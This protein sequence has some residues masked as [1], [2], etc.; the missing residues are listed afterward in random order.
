MKKITKTTEPSS[1][2]SYR[3]SIAHERLLDANVY[4]DYPHKTKQGCS[5]GDRNNLRLQL[6]KEQGYICCYCMSRINC[7][8]SK[9]EHLKPQ[10][11]FRDKQIDY[12][13]LFIACDGGEGLAQNK[14]YCD[15]K[16]SEIELKAIDF[17]DNIQDY[18][19]YKKEAQKVIILSNNTDLSDDIN[20]L[21]LNVDRLA[22]NRKEAYD[23]V[24][25][26]LSI[27]NFSKNAIKKTLEYYKQMHNGKYEPYCE[28]IV[29][30][31]TKK[32][33][34]QGVTP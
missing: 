18:L 21:N 4:E 31:L 30:F 17:L 24:I 27:K 8:N 34:Q 14:Q 2:T 10:S 29:Y 33:R 23:K 3:S 6:L 1:L 20:T 22:K 12:S 16:K 28:M 25:S 13:N 15:T 11:Q 9:I 19:K 5:E 7:E 26:S 32:L